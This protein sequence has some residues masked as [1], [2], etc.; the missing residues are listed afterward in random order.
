MCSPDHF[1]I[2]DVKNVHMQGNVGQVDATLFKAQWQS[3][4]DAFKAELD[5]GN[6]DRLAVIQGAP[7]CEDMV[8]CANQSFPWLDKNDQPLV[9]MSRMKYPSR[10]HEV[11]YFEEYYRSLNYK[12][13]QPPGD[14]L[15]EGMGDLIPVPGKKIIFGG[16]G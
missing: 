9:I 2:V 5:Q 4:Y 3:I 12:I 8:F 7:G 15:L 11:V 10:Q 16:Y 14:G 6:L 1:K 13:I